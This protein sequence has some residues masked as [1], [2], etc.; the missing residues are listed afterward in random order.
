MPLRLLA[1]DL[2]GALDS[3]VAFCG[4]RGPVPV[5]LQR[6]ASAADAALDLGCRDGSEAQ[7]IAATAAA[8]PFLTGA[9]LAFLKI[10]SLLRGHWAAMLAAVWRTG[11]FRA[12][13]LAPAFPA[14]G[15]LT[16]QGR[17]Y[18]RDPDGALQPLPVDPA[19]ALAAHGIRLSRQADGVRLCDAASDAD[20]ATLVAR[21]HATPGPLL[22]CGAGGLAAAL[23][24]VP[25]PRAAPLQAP[26]LAIVGTCHP[27]TERQLQH[28]R[29]ATG[30]A[31]LLLRGAPAEATAIAA[32]LD[33]TGFCLV[34]A[35]I[36]PGTAP[37]QAAA[38]IRACLGHILP[39]LPPPAT[40]LVTGGET[41]RG[42]CELLGATRVE[43]AAEVARGIPVSRLCGG[44]WDGVRLVSKSGAFGAADLLT[45]LLTQPRRHGRV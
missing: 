27:V 39:A 29:Q 40:L 23:A 18:L 36:P 12:C 32:R 43:V 17:Q 44:A 35:D 20:L 26:L 8:A 24:G 2:T 5:F 16:V 33:R 22:W 37:P 1:D 19:A 30:E 11:A 45:A 9:G 15:R 10:D 42:V 31:P 7:A 14:Q 34:R 28:V 38:R 4:A 21:A 41:L 3:A 13:L 6:P 25:V